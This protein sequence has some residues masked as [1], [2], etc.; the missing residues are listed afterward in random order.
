MDIER[1]NLEILFQKIPY[2]YVIQKDDSFHRCCAY[3]KIAENLYMR[4]AADVFP[5]ATDD[6]RR[7]SY[8]YMCEQM[9]W[10]ERKEGNIF[11]LIFDLAKR[12]LRLDGEEVECKFDNCFEGDKFH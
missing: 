7:N 6:E 12:M 1:G 5:Y 11:F 2:M 10:K 4:Y 9:Q 8:R 3:N